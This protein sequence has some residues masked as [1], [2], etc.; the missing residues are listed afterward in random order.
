MNTDYDIKIVPKNIS[1]FFTKIAITTKSLKLYKSVNF[2]VKIYDHF[3]EIVEIL[4]MGLIDEDYLSW[5]NDD[6]FIK[7]YVLKELNFTEDTENPPLYNDDDYIINIVPVKME[8][9]IDKLS[10]NYHSLKLFSNV[11]FELN[12]KNSKTNIS[13]QKTMLALTNEEYLSWKND[14]TFIKKMALQAVNATEA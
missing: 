8:Y 5:S 4:Q 12:L 3:G 2:M 13:Y 11:C 14:D 7:N 1:K 9:T 10:I 6:T